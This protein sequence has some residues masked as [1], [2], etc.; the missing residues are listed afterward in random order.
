M[1]QTDMQTIIKHLEADPVVEVPLAC[2]MALTAQPA[3]LKWACNAVSTLNS[4]RLARKRRH[5]GCATQL[6]CLL[7][8][9]YDAKSE[10]I[11]PGIFRFKAEIGAR[12]DT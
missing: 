2:C 1:D 10:E 9:V 8:A 6:P 12:C 7:Q 5:R 11:G 3:S 4:T